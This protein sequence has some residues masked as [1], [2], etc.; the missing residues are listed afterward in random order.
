MFWKKKKDNKLAICSKCKSLLKVTK[1]TDSVFYVEPCKCCIP[2][3][4]S[5]NEFVIQDNKE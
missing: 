2:K 4:P 3:F 5:I 1:E